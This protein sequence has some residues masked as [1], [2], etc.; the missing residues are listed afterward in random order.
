MI[1]H[2]PTASYYKT[3]VADD[4]DNAALA[5]MLALHDDGGEDEEPVGPVLAEW[6]PERAALAAVQ[7]AMHL[8]VEAL[9]AVNGGKADMPPVPYPV[10]AVAKAREQAIHQQGIEQHRFIVATLL[11]PPTQPD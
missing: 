3:A 9:Y 4:P 7:Q 2:L 5:A 10:T 8:M 11:G 6:T 1:D